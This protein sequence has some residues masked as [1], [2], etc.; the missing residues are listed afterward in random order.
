MNY[1]DS[2]EDLMIFSPQYARAD[3]GSWARQLKKDDRAAADR[4]GDWQ[5]LRPLGLSGP[6]LVAALETDLGVGAFSVAQFLG[7]RN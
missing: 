4:H 3:D 7:P 6:R 2:V 1:T 5:P